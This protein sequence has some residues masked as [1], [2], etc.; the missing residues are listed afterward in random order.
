MAKTK[1]EITLAAVQLGSAVSD[2]KFPGDAKIGLA[3]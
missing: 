1:R 2:K 3:H